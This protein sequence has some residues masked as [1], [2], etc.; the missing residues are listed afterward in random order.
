MKNWVIFIVIMALSGCA[1]KKMQTTS[2]EIWWVNGSKVDCAGVGPMKCL[3]IQ[4][5]DTIQPGNWQNLYTEIEGFNFQNGYR[6]KVKVAEEKQNTSKIPVDGSSVKYKLVEILEKMPDPRF[7]LHDLWVLEAINDEMI[8]K[9]ENNDQRPLP[10]IEI[11]VTEMRVM[12]SD[13]CNRLTGSITKLE[14]GEIE[15]GPVAQTKKLCL[16]TDI[17]DRFNAAFAQTKKYHRDGLLL[18]FSDDSGKEL[19]RFK[20]VD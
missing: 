8:K 7:A 6:F 1:T 17:P 20:K 14:N 11:N 12:G 15:L 4:K 9:P 10:A 19:L 18:I 3:Q 2:A 5:S 13:G 16:D